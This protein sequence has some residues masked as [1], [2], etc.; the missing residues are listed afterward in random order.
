MVS[1]VINDVNPITEYDATSGQTVFNTDF[2]I[3]QEDEVKIYQYGEDDTPNDTDDILVLDVDYTLSGLG[4]DGGFTF[5]LLVAATL[6]DNLTAIR[7]IPIDRLSQYALTGKFTTADVNLDFNYQT[8]FSQDRRMYER[9]KGLYYNNGAIIADL[10]R[11][12]PQLAAKDS[13]R[14]N[15]AGTAIEAVEI[16]SH[17]VGE[18]LYGVTTGS[19]NT[20]LVTIADFEGNSDGVDLLLKINVTNTTGSTININGVGAVP[21]K[22]QNGTALAAGDLVGG[23]SYNF[24]YHDAAYYFTDMVKA[25]ETSAGILP[26]ATTVETTTGTNDT[27]AITPLKLQQKMNTAHNPTGT[28]LMWPTI[29]APSEYLNCNGAAVSRT[30]YATLFALIGTL[31]GVGDGSTTFNVPNFSGRAPIGVGTGAGLSPR[32]IAATG[33]AEENIITIAQMAAH[34]HTTPRS[35]GQGGSRNAAFADGTLQNT[36]TTSSSGSGDPH[37]TMQPFLVINFIIK[38]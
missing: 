6:H 29:T 17:L 14:M 5:T 33:G 21:I 31:Y 37:N 16:I 9:V 32:S 26:L 19:A 24:V 3:F 34:T 8:M 11:R 15:E 18:N 10:D 25:K 1:I 27:K 4:V 13:W 30:T 2:L 23:Y 7:D 22:K 28:I 36:F 38:I 12:I 20:Y 35:E